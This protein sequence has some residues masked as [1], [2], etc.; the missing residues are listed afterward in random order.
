MALS[1]EESG[2]YTVHLDLAPLTKTDSTNKK[3]AGIKSQKEKLFIRGKLMSAD[4]Q[5]S[6][7]NQLPKP[8]IKK[9]II[10][11]NTITTPCLVTKRL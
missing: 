2:G 7:I 4:W 10:K 3:A 9:G 1:P 5:K 6:G 11:K 8:P